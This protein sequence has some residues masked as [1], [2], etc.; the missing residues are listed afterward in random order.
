MRR[1]REAEPRELSEEQTR[2]LREAADDLIFGTAPGEANRLALAS[3][4]AVLMAVRNTN[5]LHPQWIDQLADD[6]EACGPTTHGARQ[7]TVVR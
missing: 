5:P 4:R 1:L 3:A 6:L 7:W 2:T